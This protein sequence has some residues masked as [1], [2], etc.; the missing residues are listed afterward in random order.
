MEFATQLYRDMIK[1][2]LPAVAFPGVQMSPVHAKDVADA[3]CAA[4][5]N[6]NTIGRIIELAGPE[7]LE[8][9]EIVRRVA[10]TADRSKIILPMPLW[11]MRIGA[12]L[13]DWLSFYPVTREQLTMLEEGNTGTA[14]VLESLIGLRAQEFSSDSLRYLKC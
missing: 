12:A 13:F 4:L 9:R 11:V 8:W 7:T 1:P 5:T 2:P 10:A 6:D 3:F 14:A